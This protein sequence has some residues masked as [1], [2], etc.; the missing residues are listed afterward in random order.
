M[1]YPLGAVIPITVTIRDAAGVAANATLVQ[2]T[3]TLPDGTTSGPTTVT[4]TVG[5]YPYDYAAPVGGHYT[6]VMVAT[7]TNAGS[8][9]GS[10]DVAPRAQSGPQRYATLADLQAQITDRTSEAPRL[11]ALLDAASTAV[12]NHCGRRFTRG[13]TVTDRLFAP[14]MSDELLVDDIAT[15][16]GL[17]VSTGLGASWS[18]VP[19]S[20][21]YPYP[22]NSDSY[23][24]PYTKIVG[25][26]SPSALPTVKVSAVWGWLAVPG[27]V[28]ESV[29]LLASRLA[30][31]RS[32]PTGV[33]GFGDYGVVRISTT[34]AD[35][36][37]LLS[38]YTL[39]G[40][41]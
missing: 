16:T 36:R 29:L 3:I 1:S 28:A 8:W 23:G 2:L 34:D 4:G 19:A 37:E 31:R 39:P 10:F 33:A 41:A 13:A 6:W 14:R 21:Y 32:S 30:S 17:I 9:E 25:S 7:G 24:R 11:L 5:V 18:V 22:L 38:N 20:A 26:F 35:V 15:T 12:E 40:I 27:P